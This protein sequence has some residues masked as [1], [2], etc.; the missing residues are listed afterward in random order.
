MKELHRVSVRKID[1]HNHIWLP[2]DPDGDGLVAA[3]D[4]MGIERVLV[5]ACPKDIWSYTGD[6]DD[7]V[8]AIKRHPG[9][10]MGT[11]HLDFRHGARKC[12]SRIRRYA[13]AGLI[14]AKMFP[15]LGFRPDD[16]AHY[17]IYAEMAKHRLFAAYHLGYLAGSDVRPVPM[18]G[19][20]ADA[21][22]LEEIAILF[23]TMKFVICHMGGNPGYQQTLCVL[24]YYPNIWADT[25]PGHGIE[26][27]QFMGKLVSIVTWD[28]ILFG[29][30]SGPE[31]WRDQLRFW[32]ANAAELGYSDKLPAML[33]GNAKRFLE[34][35]G[36]R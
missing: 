35:L 29:S 33:Y 6:N 7:I 34:E 4:K 16:P 30:D 28:K 24:R 25:A 15:S 27:F 11:M 23:P 14:G 32:S 31:N 36:R 17:P 21:F 5:H 18:S 26:A 9:R 8:R 19:K 1:F 13:D 22:S 20:Y 12:V 2:G 3:M 10:I